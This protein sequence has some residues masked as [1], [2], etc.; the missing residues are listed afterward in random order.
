[1]NDEITTMRDFVQ[2]KERYDYDFGPMKNWVQYDT[3]QDASYFGVWVEP[4]KRLIFTFA[5]G[6][7]TLMECH[8]RRAFVAELARMAQFYGPPP[9]MATGYDADGTRTVYY[10]VRPTGLEEEEET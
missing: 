9:P 1:M 7:E 5:E 2:H 3:T 10:D 8:S 6:D 4:R